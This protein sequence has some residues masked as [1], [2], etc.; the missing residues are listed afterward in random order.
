MEPRTRPDEEPRPQVGQLVAAPEGRPWMLFEG[1]VVFRRPEDADGAGEGLLAFLATC[2]DPAC[3][4]SDMTLLVAPVADRTV[5]ALVAGDDLPFDGFSYAFASVDLETGEVRADPAGL[6]LPASDEAIARI[7]RALDG[8]LLDELWDRRSRTKGIEQR[9][10]TAELVADGPVFAGSVFADE[11]PDVYVLD[12]RRFW[13]DDVHCIEPGC[14]CGYLG[15]DVAEEPALDDADGEFRSIGD[16]ELDD[17]GTPIGRTAPPEHGP[18]LDRI[19]EAVRGR[20]DVA[21]RYP[22]RRR[23]LLE[24]RGREPARAP[25]PPPPPPPAPP[26]VG[27]NEPCPC[28]SGKKH[29]KCCGG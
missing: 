3:P 14:D 9:I 7:R 18:L 22:A 16:I 13:V 15:L 4:C 17:D 6:G 25:A 8:E 11:R 23:R 1:A 5:R 26:R 28:G 19:W 24:L 27:R 2:P 20:H 21:S 12:G 10:D 29:K